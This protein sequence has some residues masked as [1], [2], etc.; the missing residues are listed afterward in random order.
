LNKISLKFK[1]NQN[2]AMHNAKILEKHGYD[3]EKVIASIHPIPLS[4][5]LEFKPSQG[6]EEL[7]QHH[8]H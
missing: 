4:Y 1:K 5:G 8:P 7:L 2:A 6:L 3:I